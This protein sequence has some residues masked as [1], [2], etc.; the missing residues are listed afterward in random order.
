MRVRRESRDN[1]FTH[2]D[3]TKEDSQFI[4]WAAMAFFP[5]PGIPSSSI[6][7]EVEGR[8]GNFDTN[9]FK[10]WYPQNGTKWLST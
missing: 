2:T 7:K 8:E 5:I 1:D 6:F 10:R 9:I 3:F 4:S